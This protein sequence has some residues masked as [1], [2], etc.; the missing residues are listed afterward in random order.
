MT[1]TMGQGDPP[2]NVRLFWRFLLRKSLPVGLPLPPRLR[3]FW[4]RRLALPEVQRRRQ[5]ARQA[6][7]QPRRATHPRPRPRRRSAPVRTRSRARPLARRAVDQTRPR[8]P[9]GA[10]VSRERTLPPS[11]RRIRRISSTVRERRRR[12]PRSVPIRGG[13]VRADRVRV[14]ARGRRRPVFARV[15]VRRRRRTGSR[16]ARGGSRGPK[17]TPRRRRRRR[18]RH[19]HRLDL[20]HEHVSPRFRELRGGDGDSQ[21]PAHRLRR[22]HRDSTHRTH[23]RKPRPQSPPPPPWGRVRSRTSPETASPSF[24]A[25]AAGR[26]PRTSGREAWTRC[27]VAR[28]CLP[29]PSSRCDRRRLFGIL[30]VRHR[31]SSPRSSPRARWW[32]ARWTWRPATPR[33]YF[34]EVAS[35]YATD[36]DERERL[37]HFAS[38]A[39]RDE[40]YRYNQRERRT[41]LE[42]LSDFPSV[43][44]PLEW[45]LQT[46]PRLRPR[47][48]S[49]SSSPETD[50]DALHLTVSLARWKTHYGRERVGLCSSALARTSPPGT[51]LAAWIVSGGL[52]APPRD[53]PLVAVCAGSGAA[54]IRSLARRRAAAARRR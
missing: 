14:H 54:P 2:A 22:G 3:V 35:R 40:L 50:G 9:R 41:L 12:R 26:Y 8:V 44:M 10:G 34:F 32:R 23:A 24:L 45:L 29:T 46:A 18:R 17:T 33:R 11:R 28:A 52:R 38:A 31:V 13:D 36:P 51:R 21:R 53:A 42:F 30:R 47:L 5:E 49:V 43:A 37:A 25:D 19:R 1:S 20:E 15:P 7:A 39:G 6:P 48:F 16:R 27:C 4:P